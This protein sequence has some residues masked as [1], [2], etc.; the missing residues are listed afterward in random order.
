MSLARVLV[1]NFKAQNMRF[2]TSRSTSERALE[3][4]RVLQRS[5][6]LSWFCL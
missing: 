1:L 6:D 3:V 4:G 2:F 5:L